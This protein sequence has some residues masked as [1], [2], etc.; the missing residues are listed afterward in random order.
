MKSSFKIF[1]I[2]GI[3][4]ELHISFLLLMVI[5]FALAFFGVFTYYVAFLIVLLFFTVV[6]HE[7]SHSYVAKRYGVPVER[8]I[9]LPIGGVSAMG[10][11][12]KYPSQELKIAISGPLTN[13]V[14]AFLCL[15]GLLINGGI[16][17]LS[18]T[19][20]FIS[21]TP[22]ADLNLFLSNFLGINLV[23]GVFNLLPAFPMDGG[24]VLRAFLAERMSYVKATKT[25]ASIGK[26]FAILLVILGI[27]FN[28]FLI[29]I[30]IFIYIGAEQEYN[31]IM[32]SS[33]LEGLFVK[34]IMTRN[35]D[36]LTP[37]IPVADALSTM[38]RQRHMG[39]PVM[40]RNHIV[41]IITFEDISRIPE[42]NRNI[43]IKEIMSKNIISAAPN[44]PVFESFEKISRNNIGR[45]PVIENNELVGIISK[46]D[47]MKAL[48]MLDAKSK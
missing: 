10:E 41:G 13:I 27:F 43:Q 36:T 16:Q 22:T 14:I 29:L 40:E 31:A 8:I 1:S 6:I 18:W 7:F 28:F 47:V 30:A 12:P 32:V 37:D 48:K 45:L 39:Y 38:F 24:R 3:P 19:S 35:V 2:S 34:D 5:I 23:L 21:N 17:S 20:F 25:A 26:Q 33:A 44:E 15:I 42:D 11:I 9:L 4:V 46:T